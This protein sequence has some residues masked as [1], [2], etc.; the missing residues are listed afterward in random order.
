MINKSCH[1]RT[2]ELREFGFGKRVLE[3]HMA[4]VFIDMNK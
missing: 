1:W 2:E 3:E 4:G